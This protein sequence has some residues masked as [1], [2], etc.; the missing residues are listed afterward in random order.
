M[1]SARVKAAVVVA[2]TAVGADAR[3]EVEAVTGVD[4]VVVERAT[5]CLRKIQAALS[6]VNLRPSPAAAGHFR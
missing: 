5:N 3:A 1:K 6:L 2:V 4:V